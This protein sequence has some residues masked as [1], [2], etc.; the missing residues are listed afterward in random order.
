M[1]EYGREAQV[2][3][4]DWFGGHLDGDDFVDGEAQQFNVPSSV[5]SCVANED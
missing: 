1:G 3:S 2:S 4:K 5:S